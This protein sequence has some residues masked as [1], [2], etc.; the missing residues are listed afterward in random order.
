MTFKT[1]FRI[2][3]L[4][5]YTA[6]LLALVATCNGQAQTPHKQQEHTSSSLHLAASL[7]S[8]WK[9]PASDKP[10]DDVDSPLEKVGPRRVAVL[11]DF[12][13]SIDRYGLYVPSAESFEPLIEHVLHNGGELGV[14]AIQEDSALPLVRVRIKPP[15]A[16]PPEPPRHRN[17]LIN[18]RRRAEYEA[19]LKAYNAE[20][21]ERLRRAR[22]RIGVFRKRLKALLDRSADRERT[23]LFGNLM[24]ANRFLMEPQVGWQTGAPLKCV[25]LLQTDGDDTA[26]SNFFRPD[27]SVL[28]ILV[29]GSAGP[30]DLDP[31]NP[32]TFEGFDAAID[33]IS[34][35]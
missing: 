11:L 27:P 15:K 14:G 9:I 7:D 26:G 10:T 24:R 12:T 23:D 20:E 31:F 3:L 35:L 1:K 32:I 17:P 16:T 8:R 30:G 4:V 21:R 2:A 18:N 19:D 29:N 5:L 13:L 28:I 33:F 34:H 25:L 6:G 22:T